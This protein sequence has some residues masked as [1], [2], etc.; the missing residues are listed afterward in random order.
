MGTGRLTTVESITA[1]QGDLAGRIRQKYDRN[2]S[3]LWII[4]KLGAD[5]IAIHTRHHDVKKYLFRL[6]GADRVI[7]RPLLPLFAYS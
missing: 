7:C 1:S 6:C 2:M 3:C 5:F 4:L